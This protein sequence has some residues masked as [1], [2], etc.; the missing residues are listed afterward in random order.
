MDL[1]QLEKFYKLCPR[2]TNLS[3]QLT[4]KNQEKIEKI[5]IF[6]DLKTLEFSTGY[7][8]FVPVELLKNYIES[9]KDDNK[10]EKITFPSMD[11]YN[12]LSLYESLFRKV[13]L[14]SFKR[15]KDFLTDIAGAKS[16][17]SWIEKSSTIQLIEL[18]R[19]PF[20]FFLKFR[21]FQNIN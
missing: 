20:L 6:E 1:S 3:L 19:K 7:D 10:L 16:I 2:E 5:L 9:L 13:N 17:A 4:K 8:T 12:I 14:K 21:L 15:K 11:G 18:N